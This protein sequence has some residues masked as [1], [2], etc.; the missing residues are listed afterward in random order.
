MKRAPLFGF[1]FGCVCEV[2]KA[3]NELVLR[4]LPEAKETGV[5]KVLHLIAFFLAHPKPLILPTTSASLF[6]PLT[7][8]QPLPCFLKPLAG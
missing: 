2:G 7:G 3:E 6:S 4:I 5:S 1:I 8:T